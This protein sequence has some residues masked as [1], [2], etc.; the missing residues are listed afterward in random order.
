[1]N[2]HVE[3]PEIERITKLD[4]GRRQLSMAIRLF[5]GIATWLPYMH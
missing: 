3:Q 1:M 5:L 2:T 4:A